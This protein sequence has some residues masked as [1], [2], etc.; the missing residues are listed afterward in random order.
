MFF[1]SAPLIFG[2]IALFSI[3]Q[4]EPL[5][6]NIPMEALIILCCMWAPAAAPAAA[7]VFSFKYM[8][9]TAAGAK[10]ISYIFFLIHTLLGHLPALTD[11]AMA[12]LPLRTVRLTAAFIPLAVGMLLIDA[13]AGQLRFKEWA[14]RLKFQVFPVVPIMG[15]IILSD[16]FVYAPLQAQT[17]VF[18]RPWLYAAGALAFL[19]GTY[20][21]APSLLRRVW[22][23]SPLEEG[24][25]MQKIRAV[26]DRH[27][28]SFRGVTV[29][30]AGPSFCNA[31]AAGLLPRRQEIF[32]SEALLNM[33]DADEMEA[34]AAHEIGHLKRGHLWLYLLFSL[35][36]AAVSM[37]L[38]AA[39]SSYAPELLETRFS[40]TIMAAA[41][42]FLY[43]A[44]LLGFVSR[45][46]ERQAD[47]FA[48]VNA[49]DPT[50][51]P[52]ALSKLHNETVDS[53]RRRLRLPRFLRTHPPIIERIEFAIRAAENEP[54]T[55]S[56]AKPLWVSKAVAAATPLLFLA[57]ILFRGAYLPTKAEAAEAVSRIY[58]R[59]AKNAEREIEQ[60]TEE[61]SKKRE[62]LSQRRSRLIDHAQALVT[63]GLEADPENKDL[64]YLQGKA[65]LYLNNI[66][67]AEAAFL[68]AL[69]ADP[70]H[71]ETLWALASLRFDQR[72]LREAAD[73]VERFAAAW[74]YKS[75]ALE[76]A[77]DIR[78]LDRELERE[79]EREMKDDP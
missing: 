77:K 75:D 26:A 22:R 45:Q 8:R 18:E 66:E 34:V 9:E 16:L 67:E 59:E 10:L 14:G 37:L 36:Y 2:L 29:W 76:I 65:S 52:R 42:F 11:A 54:S 27:N 68:R 61:E 41:L 47:Q 19:C 48:A 24:E 21:F 3:E 71:P 51:Y 17:A 73:L 74:P 1:I 43:F 15:F 58:L 32:V 63:K 55:A 69:S 46:F 62:K 30:H 57:L 72:R 60:L 70:T 4:V 13:A 33:L 49:S 44:L 35:S 39:I 7:R 56:Y 28:L 64:V 5:P 79:I 50:A 53:G 23:S 12:W 6:S 40:M 31:A 20:A 78:E 38:F 25:L